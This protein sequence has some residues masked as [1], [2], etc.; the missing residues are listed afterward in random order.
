MNGQWE[1]ACGANTELCASIHSVLKWLPEKSEREA[2]ESDCPGRE[3]Q[4][5]VQ[6]PRCKSAHGTKGCWIYLPI[7][8]SRG[9]GLKR[10]VKAA[11]EVLTWIYRYPPLCPGTH[12]RVNFSRSVPAAK[13]Y[14]KNTFALDLQTVKVMSVEM[15]NRCPFM[16]F[17]RLCI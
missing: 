2:H 11:H 17:C 5:R 12:A 7:V 14:C 1:L 9:A 15:N 10:S 3:E 8:D 4:R 16:E 13:E 6:G